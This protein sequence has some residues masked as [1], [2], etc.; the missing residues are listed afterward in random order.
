MAEQERDTPFSLGSIKYKYLITSNKRGVGKTS[1]ATNLAVALSKRE[2][3][4]GLIDLDLHGTDNLNILRLNG[5][6]EID[7]NKRVIPKLSSKYLKTIS[8]KASKQNIGQ[9]EVW[10]DDLSTRVIGQFVADIDWGDLDYLFV[11]APPG[12]GKASLAVIQSILG[13]KVIFVSTPEKEPLPQLAELIKFYQTAQIPIVGLIENMSGFW[14]EDCARTGESTF[15]ESNIMNVDY[16][17]RIP[18]DPHMADF[19]SSDQFFTEIYPNS[20]AT[21]G[22]ELVVDKIL[23]DSR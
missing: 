3:K 10:T 21:H 18:F 5:F 4:V 2:K 12:K 14:C 7:E 8:I 1:L 17:G 13:A 22:Y 20:E 9:D 23:E 11:D 6:Y 19:T 16:L 15:R